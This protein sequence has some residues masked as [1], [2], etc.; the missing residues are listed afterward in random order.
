MD[1]VL[2]VL[3]LMILAYLVY[4]A[5]QVDDVKRRQRQTL[6]LLSRATTRQSS[7]ANRP[8]MQRSPQ[9]DAKART[10]RRDSNDLEATGRM[11]MAVHRKKVDFASTE[12]DS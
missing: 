9:V 1:W 2:L 7:V 12:S 6:T 3:G 4:V 10:V 8:T 5:R 11:S